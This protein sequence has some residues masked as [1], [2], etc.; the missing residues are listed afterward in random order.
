MS[1]DCAHVAAGG[2]HQHGISEHLKWRANRRSIGFL[3][4]GK[5]A[6]FTGK[7]VNNAF[8]VSHGNQPALDNVSNLICAYCGVIS[9]TNPGQTTEQIP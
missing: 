1:L 9:I 4:R 7:E 3:T 6:I 8:C 5:A 2:L